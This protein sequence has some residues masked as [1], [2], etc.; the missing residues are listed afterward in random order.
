MARVSALLSMGLGAGCATTAP[1]PPAAHQSASL[2]VE[3]SVRLAWLP[4]DEY[5]FPDVAA[6]LN[7]RMEAVHL[8]G[9]DVSFRAPVSMEVAQLSLECVAQ[10]AACY[11][12]VGTS[13]QANRL[14]WAEL[15]AVGSGRRRL[16]AVVTVFDVDQKRMLRR[17][18]ETYDGRETALQQL[19]R[20]MLTV[21]GD[22]AAIAPPPEASTP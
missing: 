3:R 21:L 19:D 12:Q 20:L 15:V 7:D 14:L 9:V 5:A 18:E 2:S 17:A 11:T 16:K 6:A 22:S 8:S 13:L 1:P 4:A 10:T